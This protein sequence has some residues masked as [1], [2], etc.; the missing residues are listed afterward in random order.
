MNSVS[1]HQAVQVSRAITLDD[2]LL[3]TNAEVL[4]ASIHPVGDEFSEIRAMNRL[5]V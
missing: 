5:D 1:E 4:F 3:G 2:D